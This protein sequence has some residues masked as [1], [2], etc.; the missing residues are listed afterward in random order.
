MPPRIYSHSALEAGICEAKGIDAL[1]PRYGKVGPARQGQVGHRLAETY[2]RHLSTQQLDTDFEEGARIWANLT[3]QASPDDIAA[4]EAAATSFIL[5]NTYQWVVGAKNLVLESPRFFTVP[6]RKEVPADKVHLLTG[7]VFRVTLDMSWTGSAPQPGTV[8]DDVKHHMLDWK[9]HRVIEHV[10]APERN[11]QLL[12]YASA[13]YG[14]EAGDVGAWIGFCRA[15]YYEGATFSPS[16]RAAAWREHV[17]EAIARFEA[18]LDHPPQDPDRTVGAHCRHCDLLNGCDAA[19]RY[20]YVQPWTDHATREEKMIGLQLS[21]AISSSL[22]REL[23]A[24]INESG[25]VVDDDLEAVIEEVEQLSF[26]RDEVL[27]VTADDVPPEM[28]DRAFRAN[29]TKLAD[30]LKKAAV[31]PARRKEIEEELRVTSERKLNS[32]LKVRKV[33]DIREVSEANSN[34]EDGTA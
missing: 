20:P 31:K 27:R 29:K 1:K 2:L 5:D 24:T 14:P 11:R 25:S 12:R 7:A 28:L 30:A 33:R 3:S 9:F 18:M 10:T 6:D 32:V 22:A 15:K 4:I 34:E 23:K 21:K 16:H 13:I 19:Q 8:D 17:V 26:S